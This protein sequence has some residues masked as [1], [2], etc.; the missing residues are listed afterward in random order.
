MGYSPGRKKLKT[1]IVHKGFRKIKRK[2][3]DEPDYIRKV[4]SGFK[5]GFSLLD[6]SSAYGD[7]KLILKSIQKCGLKREDLILTTRISNK[8]QFNGNIR[9][10]FSRLLKG[11]NTDFFDIL[12]FHWPVTD[13]YITTWEEIIRL[14]EEGYCK[15]IGVANCHQHHIEELIKSTS[16]KPQVNQIEVHPLFSQKPL[17][18][19]CQSQEIQVEAYT[20]LA[21]MDERLV[22]LPL[23]K[24]LQKKYNKSISQLVL[25]WHIQNGIIP[26]FRSM[27]PSRFKENLDIF[28]FEIDNE[29]MLLIDGI[30][31]NSRLRYDPDNCDF[32]IL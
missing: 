4:E 9:E 31:I 20:P 26:V 32:T 8:A 30:N 14:K 10:E 19:Y 27:N 13:K 18:E 2:V 3:Y 11:F 28:D 1:D 6:W 12:M 7:G 29:D 15:N 17:I 24:N 25:R 5:A 16:V 21:R 23:W 22:R